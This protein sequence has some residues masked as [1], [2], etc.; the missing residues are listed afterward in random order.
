MAKNK[1]SGIPHYEL[2]FV[3]PNKFTI[4]ELK[5]VIKK[6]S[7]IITD[8]GGKITYSEEWGNK[9]LAYPIKHFTH[10]YYNLFE[11][12]ASSEKVAQINN[13]IKMDSDIIRHLIIS[14]PSR[15]L[16]EIKE[17]KKAETERRE[18]SKIEKGAKLEKRKVGKKTKKKD[19]PSKNKVVSEKE[20][21]AE[22]KQKKDDKKM[23]LE[24]LD[25]K[26]D[27]ILETNDLL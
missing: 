7:D 9:K 26:L 5:P 4:D 18:A 13:I 25:E 14:K 24:D 6:I 22:K 17:E 21:A 20:V 8:N 10:G 2:L 16:E 27:K 12:D 15:T 1:K 23:N 11:F 19:E 3:V